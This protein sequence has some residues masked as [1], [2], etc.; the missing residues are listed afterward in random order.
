M[1]SALAEMTGQKA[2]HLLD[3]AETLSQVDPDAVTYHAEG[4][5]DEYVQNLDLDR[6]CARSACPVLLIQ[7]D[8]AR[9]AMIADEDVAHALSL[10]AN[11]R[12]CAS[13]A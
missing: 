12:T 7:G 1:A 13:R 2:A 11:G 5:I 4:R 3:W 10:L 8:P 6:R 9:G